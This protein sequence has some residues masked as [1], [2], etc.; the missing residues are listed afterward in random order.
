M[1]LHIP[2]VLQTQWFEFFFAQR[3]SLKARELVAI[4]RRTFVYKISI[5]SVVVIHKIS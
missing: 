2:A 3:A 1:A 4:L 5:E